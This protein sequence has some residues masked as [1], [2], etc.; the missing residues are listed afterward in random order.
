MLALRVLLRSFFLVATMLF[1]GYSTA[2]SYA[3]YSAVGGYNGPTDPIITE[4]IYYISSTYYNFPTKAQMRI[5]EVQL[6][7]IR[8]AMDLIERDSNVGLKFIFGGSYDAYALENRTA[9]YN[10]PMF[11]RRIYIDLTGRKYTGEAT[12]NSGEHAGKARPSGLDSY[13]PYFSGGIEWLNTKAF[14][15]NHPRTNMSSTYVHEV[16]HILGLD[17]STAVDSRM[18]YNNPTWEGLAEDD[19]M[20]LYQIYGGPYRNQIKVHATLNGANAPGAEIV[21]VNKETGRS[22]ITFTG[23]GTAIS[24]TK[25]IEPGIYWVVGREMTPT[26]PCFVNPTRGFLTS[27]YVNENTST[28]NPASAAEIEIKDDTSIDLSLKL[29]AGTKRFDCY[30]PYPT[31]DNRA[32]NYKSLQN[33]YSSQPG[34]FLIGTL[35]TDKNTLDSDH[36]TSTDINSG[37][38]P[39]IQVSH[40]GTKPGVKILSSVW[41]KPQ[42]IYDT[43]NVPEATM[44]EMSVADDAKPGNYAALCSA[45]GEYAL[46]ATV[47]NVRNDV[48]TE[49]GY[50]ELFPELESIMTDASM[51]ANV[52]EIA[53]GQYTGGLKE[54]KKPTVSPFGLACGDV[55]G[56]S[57][58]ASFILLAAALLAPLTFRRR[59]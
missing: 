31:A 30:Y 58:S 20:G 27:F 24:T 40:I 23:Y 48:Q 1:G 41:G 21:F 47:H 52:Y 29:I 32:E 39:T 26:G 16:L 3:L 44:L 42:A 17:H 33:G 19:V 37:V 56:T 45:D 12:A 59:K 10:D 34:A 54:S 11:D 9:N 51:P 38:H 50:G 22:V 5:T 15:I 49:K 55:G 18:S 36:I 53:R 25:S 2:L 57:K 13:A 14:D 8:H 7:Q 46:S 4:F 28:N 43:T 6:K 35:Y